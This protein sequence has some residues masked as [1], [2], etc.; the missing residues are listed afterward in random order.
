MRIGIL[1]PLEV[2]DEAGQLVQLGGPRLRALLIRLARR[3]QRVGE[4][5]QRRH[6]ARFFGAEHA[7]LA[8]TV[9]MT[10]EVDRS[11]D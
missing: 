4:Q 9:R 5:Q 11:R 8:S 6:Q 1:G 10:A 3:M 7:G 2:R